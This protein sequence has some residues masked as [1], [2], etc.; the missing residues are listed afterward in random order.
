MLL[1]LPVVATAGWF[2]WQ[3]VQGRPARAT[4]GSATHNAQTPVPAPKDAHPQRIR[5]IA[6]GDFL[7]HDA[8]NKAAKKPDGT[9]D[10][11]PMM[12]SFTPIFNAADIRF[13]NLSAVTGGARFGI[14]GY[15][16]FNGPTEFSRDMGRLGCNL[17]N[18][19]T[20]HSFDRNQAAIDVTLDTWAQVPGMLAVA[21]QNRS[22]QEQQQ[23]RY[24]TVKGVK[25]AFLAYTTY[26]NTDAPVQDSYGVNVYNRKFAA[27]QIAAAK[28][29]GAQII[30]ASMRWGTEYSPT[31]TAQQT[32]EAHFLAD[33]GV[34][35]VI[36]HGTHVLQ[37]VTRIAGASGKQTLVWYGIGNFLTSQDQKETLF[38]GLPVVDFDIP[39]LKITSVAFL[40]IYMHYEWTAAQRAASD[41]L[42]RHDLKMYLLD[43]AT[44]PMIDA[45][46]LGTTVAEQRQRMQGMLNANF[47]VPMITAAQYLSS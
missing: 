39:T 2:G 16:K 40:P 27:Q 26:I 13:C 38:N 46:Q 28:A 9:Y 17:V 31:V 3:K 37:P 20:N 12:A 33:Q 36:G 21:G 25:F 18:T 44:Q 15:P 34:D 29:N 30:I 42:A 10:Y 11:L 32:S 1:L 35:L 41:L 14:S 7:P 5:L 19:G 45:Q 8:V 23:V 6:A 22:A 43:D 4:N 24:F 47:A